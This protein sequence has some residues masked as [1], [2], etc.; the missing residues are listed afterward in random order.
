[1]NIDVGQLA[2]LVGLGN[3]LLLLLRPIA[4]LHTR[5]DRNETAIKHLEVD[6]ARMQT[7]WDRPR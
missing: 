7:D 2:L 6:F 3:G 5:I 1:L 4:R